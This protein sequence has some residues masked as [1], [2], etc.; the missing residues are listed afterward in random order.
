MKTQDYTNLP[1]GSRSKRDSIGRTPGPS[2]HTNLKGKMK[3][4]KEIVKLKEIRKLL[5]ELPQ[6]D[7]H[8]LAALFCVDAAIRHLELNNHRARVLKEENEG[9]TI[10]I[11]AR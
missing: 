6:H 2:K 3:N 9:R 4:K 11:Q 1:R 8:V 7:M 5:C 10:P